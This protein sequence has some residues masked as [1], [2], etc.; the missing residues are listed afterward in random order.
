MTRPCPHCHRRQ[1]IKGRDVCQRCERDMRHGPKHEPKCSVC[2]D[3]GKI[4]VGGCDIPGCMHYRVC[5][6]SVRIPDL[7][8]IEFKL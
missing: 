3:A 2:N 7:I 6:C 4:Y 5:G 8:T 1:C